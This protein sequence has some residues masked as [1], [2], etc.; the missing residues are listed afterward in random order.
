MKNQ[1]VFCASWKPMLVLGD[2]MFQE[3]C[4]WFARDCHKHLRDLPQLHQLKIKGD[5]HCNCQT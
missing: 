2:D 3:K 1:Y 4:Y 5:S